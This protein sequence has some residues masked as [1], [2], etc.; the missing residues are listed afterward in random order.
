MMSIGC[1]PPAEAFELQ[2]MKLRE[3]ETWKE[4]EELS[5]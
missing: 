1:L 2:E 5:W 4:E 3:A